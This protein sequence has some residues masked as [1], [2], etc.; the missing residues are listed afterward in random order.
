M[1]SASP[2]PTLATT[3]SE[4]TPLSATVGRVRS[5]VERVEKGREK[6]GRSKLA[7][8]RADALD[9]HP[10]PVLDSAY[11]HSPALLPLAG[12]HTPPAFYAL[13]PEGQ[14]QV[15]RRVREEAERNA[16]K[17]AEAEALTVAKE[18]EQLEIAKATQ[19]LMAAT[20]AK[21]KEHRRPQLGESGISSVA[22]WPRM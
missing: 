8:Q 5:R 4:P 12:H 13:T 16:A 9:A 11:P 10:T 7:K 17:Q 1:V 15:A 6:R 18:L 14:A 2:T 19:E 3:R 20:A 22:N 21:L